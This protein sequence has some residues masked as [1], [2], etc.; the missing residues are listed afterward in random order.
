MDIVIIRLNF[1]SK[2]HVKCKFV[3]KIDFISKHIQFIL[4]RSCTKMPTLPTLCITG[5]FDCL[6]SDD[7]LNRQKHDAQ[8]L[9][10]WNAHP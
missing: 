2:H 8:F 3:A 5:K 1:N 6:L 7:V 10:H 4:I 9:F